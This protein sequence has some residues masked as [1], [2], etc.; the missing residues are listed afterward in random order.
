MSNTPTRDTPCVSPAAV[1]I[2]AGEPST[3]RI[4]L[5]W[6]ELEANVGLEALKTDASVGLTNPESAERLSTYGSNEL[7][8]R[9]SRARG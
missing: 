8:G 3:P 1:R 9:G 5:K 4:A 6:H 7:E 2:P